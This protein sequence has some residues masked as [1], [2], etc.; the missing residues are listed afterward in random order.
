[1]ALPAS[2]WDNIVHQNENFGVIMNVSNSYTA[3][4]A[5]SFSS[6][7]EISLL[8]TKAKDESDTTIYHLKLVYNNED[9]KVKNILTDICQHPTLDK[10]FQKIQN[11]RC[12]PMSNK[13]CIYSSKNMLF[14]LRAINTFLLKDVIPIDDAE[15]MLAL[16]E[17]TP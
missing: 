4:I 2:N 9:I 12:T 1:M 6:F 10:G 3:H 11:Y 5:D 8:G 7:K 17:A 15:A 16:L 13:E 14:M